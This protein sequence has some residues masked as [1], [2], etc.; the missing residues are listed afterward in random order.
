MALKLVYRTTKPWLPR[1]GKLAT[2]LT[3]EVGTVRKCFRPPHHPL[4]RELLLKAKPSALTPPSN[5][6]HLPLLPTTDTG[7]KKF[8]RKKIIKRHLG[9][10]F[11]I[12]MCYNITRYDKKLMKIIRE[13]Q[14]DGKKTFYCRQLENEY[15]RGKR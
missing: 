2:K 5:T 10:A 11:I 9:I 8:Q 14:N 3:D 7:F 4:P 12:F 13:K 15:D 6:P 1:S